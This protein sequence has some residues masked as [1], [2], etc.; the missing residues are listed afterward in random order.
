MLKE[1]G[2]LPFL[3]SMMFLQAWIHATVTAPVYALAAD[4]F[5]V[6]SISNGTLLATLILIIVFSR[7]FSHVLLR[8]ES[9][10]V[11][12]LVASTGTLLMGLGDSIASSLGYL[13]ILG[14]VLTA[15]STGGILALVGEGFARLMTAKAQILSTFLAMVGSFFLYL[16]IGSFPALL[17]LMIVM[18]FP[19][20]TVYGL[21]Y[22]F[23]LDATN[24]V[25]HAKEAN[26]EKTH[27]ALL[28]AFILAFS[29][30][31]NFLNVQ[32]SMSGN[33][34]SSD[35][36]RMVFSYALLIVTFVIF[37]ELLLERYKLTILTFSI[38]ILTSGSLFLQ[39][40]ATPGD[41]SP[42]YALMYSGYYLFVATFY[43]YLGMQAGHSGMPA[44]KIFAIGN[45]VNVLGLLI[46]TGLGSLVGN[47][48]SSW[49]TIITVI[50]IYVLFFIGLILLPQA[51]RNIFIREDDPS[52][53]VGPANQSIG[54]SV[55]CQC[56]IV[57]GHY[58]LS[59]REEEILNLLV[60]GRSVQTIA[61]T[62]F[63][64]QNTIKTHVNHIYQKLDVHTREELIQT[65]E[66]VGLSME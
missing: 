56:K 28:M 8:R 18:T 9:L 32:V 64:S 52:R 53:L 22:I 51:R 60:R 39:L 29:I 25:Y 27:S 33:I 3:I 45:C 31:L 55:R 40:F 35:I 19:L 10:V 34:A 62:T 38:V 59:R 14:T 37:S 17:S 47:L 24:P 20:V 41:I 30:P 1:R 2:F 12:S 54:D 6:F 23:G 15:I 49:A 65:V 46:G 4:G 43:S 50:F 66:A 42:V 7:C 5:I 11:I 21:S 26:V 58:H 63:L 44:F 48:V 36:W 57:S 61:A 16:F 13:T